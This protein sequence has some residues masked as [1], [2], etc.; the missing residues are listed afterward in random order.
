MKLKIRNWVALLCSMWMSFAVSVL[1]GV[2]PIPDPL[3]VFGHD[4]KNDVI[5][6]KWAIL[7]AGSYGYGNYRHQA[8]ICHAYQ[9]LKNGGLKDEN[10][11]VFMYD[12]IAHNP[13]NPNRGIIIN[14][15]NGTD[16][17]KGVPKDYTGDVTTAQN[18]YAVISGNRSALSGGSG[19][20][21][22][23]GPNDTIFIFY[24][25]HGSVGTISAMPVG[26]NVFAP[27]FVA[28]LKKKHAANSYRKMVSFPRILPNDID[29]Y[30]TTASNSQ[31]SSY[32][33]Y[34]P[35]GNPSPP[36]EYTVCLGDLYSIS[37][38]EDSDQND[39]T[40]ET[41]QQQYEIV[42]QR[43]TGSAVMQYGDTNLANDFLATYIGATPNLY[44]NTYSFEP[45]TTQTTLISQRDANLLHLHLELEKAPKGS[46]EKLKAQRKLDDEIAQRE[47]VD[48]VFNL[49]G[50]FLFREKKNSMMLHR[51]SGQ[52]LVDDWDCFR[53]L[54]KTYESQCGTLSTYGRKYTRAFANM[55]NVGISKE[56]LKV[57]SLQACLNKNHAS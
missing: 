45:S 16:V 26:D 23:S 57:A 47:H 25:D 9:V 5:G 51:P 17:Y 13:L 43:T 7:V 34:C 10:I 15:P 49:I 48:N 36:P 22:D 38:L 20:V 8:D 28:V 53:I 54:V 46:E 27:D 32:A 41:L 18:F 3:E 56:Q 50:D 42:R 24:A 4:D 14:K 2:G 30:V 21:V 33:F 31:Q 12:D 1:E 55:C 6:T 37:W 44:E 35:G 39:R 29:I 52:P 11:I 19:K 40:K